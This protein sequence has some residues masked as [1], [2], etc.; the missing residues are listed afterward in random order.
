MKKFTKVVIGSFLIGLL[1]SVI[2]SALDYVPGPERAANVYYFSFFESVIWSAFYIVPLTV[3]VGIIW[4]GVHS[5]L[6]KAKRMGPLVRGVTS[7][8]VSVALVAGI[9]ALFSKQEETNNIYLLPAGYEGEAYVFYNVKGAPEVKTEDGYRVH[10]INEEGYFATSM[11]ELSTGLVTDQ[12]FYV[13]E[14]GNRTPISD[15][16]V[17]A[18]GVGG[19]QTSEDEE[20]DLQSTGFKVVKKGCSEEFMTGSAIGEEI[21]RVRSKVLEK[22]YDIQRER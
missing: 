6:A 5:L 12:Y 9:M 13:D 1:L 19:Y 7:A 21:D 15:Q 2:A 8:I 18:Y 11:E 22:Y 4:L 17:Q 10:P 14:E 20:V 16:C 3:M